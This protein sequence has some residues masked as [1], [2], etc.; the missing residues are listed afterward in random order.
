MTSNG[1][2]DDTN[3]LLIAE[4]QRDGRVQLQRV[5]FLDVLEHPE[6]SVAMRRDADVAR[7]PR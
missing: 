5:S 2:L 1:L 6:E 7:R 4:L 3:R